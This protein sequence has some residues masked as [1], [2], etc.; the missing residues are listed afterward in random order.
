MLLNDANDIYVGKAPIKK[1]CV[2]N[3]NI[4]IKK[5]YSLEDFLRAFNDF[6]IKDDENFNYTIIGNYKVGCT[7]SRDVLGGGTSDEL[8]NFPIIGFRITNNP[9]NLIPFSVTITVNEENVTENTPEMRIEFK[10]SQATTTKD[11]FKIFARLY[12]LPR[13]TFCYIGLPKKFIPLNNI[14]FN[15]RV[16]SYQD[17]DGVFYDILDYVNIELLTVEDNIIKKKLLN[18]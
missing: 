1:V 6:N 18:N 3:K 17:F 11:T 5:N 2:G 15:F 4:W 13:N 9:T 7:I 14:K 8:N 16:Y 12:R 10:G